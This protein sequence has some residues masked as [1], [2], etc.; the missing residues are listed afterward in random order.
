MAETGKRIVVIGASGGIGMALC[1]RLS[2]KGDHVIGV[3]REPS[4]EL[5]QVAAKV[6]RADAVSGDLSPLEPLAKEPVDGL[7]YCPGT[8]TLKPFRALKI[9]DFQRDLD[10]N[11][12]G[13]VRTV[14]ALLPGLRKSNEAAVVL[15]STVA[16]RAGM[17]YHS[18]IA[19]AKA[20]VEGFAVSLAAELSGQGIRVNV[21]APSLTDTP[22][23]E[24]L[25]DT[26]TKK[27]ASAKRHPLG[28][29]GSAEDIAGAAE[30]LLSDTATWI[31]GQV[32]SVDGG[33]STLRP[34]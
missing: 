19:A 31:T 1:R 20:A 23:A 29:T 33:L 25:L 16:T 13:A 21:V 30:F 2:D 22:L 18:S 11:L 34:M 12:L 14:Q 17:N 10:I 27:E 9:E 4:D 6:I 8:I 3:S 15:F 28:R 32:I 5:Q 7:V 24:R 26:D